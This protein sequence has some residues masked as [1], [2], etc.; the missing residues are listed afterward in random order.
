MPLLS[1]FCRTMLPLL[2]QASSGNRILADVKRIVDTDRW[3][4]FDRFH[5][6]TNT[7]VE[8]Y[9]TSGAKAEV[10]AIPTGGPV[11]SGRW[12]IAKAAD[13]RSATLDV[14]HPV[15]QRILDYKQNP[16]HVIQ[17]SAATPPQG[18][19]CKLV[20]IDDENQLK[21]LGSSSLHHK[22]VLTNLNVRNHM[23]TFADKG[24][25]G[26]VTDHPIADLPN[27]TAWTKFGWGTIPLPHASVNLVGLV[28]SHSGGQ[29]LRKLILSQGPLTVRVCVDT[30]VYAGTHDLVSG[31]IVGKDDSQD[32]VW[33][34]AH[35]AE[36][37]AIDNASG[38]ALCLEIARTLESLIAAGKIARPKRTI[39]LLSGYECYSFFNYL[40]HTRR[41]QT[42]LAG[43]CIDT[44]GARPDI[45][46][47]QLSWRATIPMSAGFVDRVG[48]T[49]LKATLNR[50]QA[51]Y[52]LVEG[53]FVST[54]DT[55]I[56]DPKYGF[57]CPWITTHYRE[58][59]Q[60]WK[61]YH[62][63]ADVPTLLSPKGLKACAVGMAAYLH[64]LANAETADVIDLANSE[65]E[66]TCAQLA[67][68]TSADK[69]NYLRQQHQTTLNQLQ[70]WLWTGNRTETLKHFAQ[71]ERTVSRTGLKAKRT[72]R[73][74]NHIPYRTAPLS[75]TAENMPVHIADRIRKTNLPSWALFW[76]NG[77]RNLSDIARLLSVENGKEISLQQVTEFF[78]AHETL[79]YVRL[80]APEN[81]IRESQLVADLEKLGLNSGMEVMVHSSLSAIGHVMGGPNTV[82]DAIL[83]VIGSNATLVMP[84]FNHRGAHVYNPLTTPTTNGSIPDAFWRRPGVVRS[85]HPT[86]A[87]AAFGPKSE[88][89]CADHLSTG[90]WTANSPLSRFIHNGGYILSIG[91]THTSSTAYH[92]AEVS[93]PCGCIDPFGQT[94]RVVMP[95]GNVAEVPGLA[96]RNG[97]CPV[98]P[99]KLNSALKNRQTHGKVGLADATLVKAIDLWHARRRH[100]K[101]VCPTCPIKPRYPA[102]NRQS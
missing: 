24:A 13:I 59:T 83:S 75:P 66:Y 74:I 32:E 68:A 90:V 101:N 39:R 61:A 43:V 84:S 19:T 97:P 67:L 87:I 7:L 53:G 28:L 31:L 38:V 81:L 34:L 1:T 44:V 76:A 98:S 8:S 54:S 29:K 99:G 102:K 96:F 47:G 12:I 57:P 65:T 52:K 16:W 37:G 5:D 58:E 15:Q 51:G 88:L 20:V 25:V 73:P 6:T 80:I 82:I 78:E 70:R 64:Y 55:L 85:Q 63:S 9:E 50:I 11:G 22:I 35:S 48:A 89:F 41:L 45:C 71:C 69:A 60:T 93:V 27:A 4:S 77:E 95:D 46:N 79:D 21:N 2:D 49:I 10:Y 92:V 94:D 56:G 62:S 100:L 86:H 30:H 72:S 14:I 26:V 18:L 17:W 40:E 42:P 23:K 36:P 33:V 91:V 3:N